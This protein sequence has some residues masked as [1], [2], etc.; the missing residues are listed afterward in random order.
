MLTVNGKQT[1][2][3]ENQTVR[4]FLEEKGLEPQKVVLELN[5]EIL[6]RE[7]WSETILQD[8]DSLEIISFVGGG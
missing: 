3:K 1:E 5:K 7:N 6:S 2:F 8:G 4:N